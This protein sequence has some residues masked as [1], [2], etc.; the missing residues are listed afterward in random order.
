MSLKNT[1]NAYG[2]VTRLLHWIVMIFMITM[3]AY[4]TIMVNI[5]A[6]SW[7]FNLH[8]LTGIGILI[9][10]I[11]FLCWSLLNIKPRYPD[12]MNHFEKMLSVFV[13]YMMYALLLAMPLTGWIMATAHQKLPV[14]FGIALPFPFMPT[15]PT[16]LAWMPRAHLYL[17]W[18]LFLMLILHTCGALKHHCIDKDHVLKRM[19]SGK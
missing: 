5:K 2:Y 9:L 14:L 7:V 16:I 19:L 6:S 13:R 11:L 4:G 17:A 12:L 8:K 15:N 3:L 1:Q 18:V 10:G